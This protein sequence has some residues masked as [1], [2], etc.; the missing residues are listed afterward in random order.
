PAADT[1]SLG[2]IF[3]E[4]LTGRPPFQA[5]TPLETLEQVR[6]QEPMPLRRLQPKVPR[7]LE[8]ICLRCLQKDPRRRY[9]SAGALADDLHRFL[10]GEP[11]QARPVGQVE[12][13]ILWS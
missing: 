4:M 13:A 11:I 3:Y 9:A 7:D 2:S 12:R 6:S 5:P 8:T 10:T 1:Y